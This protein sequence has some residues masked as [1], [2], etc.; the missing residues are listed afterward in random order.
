MQA[1]WIS[2]M[3]LMNPGCFCC[4]NDEVPTQIPEPRYQYVLVD[5]FQDT[6]GA[7]YERHASWWGR[8]ADISSSGVPD[9]P[10]YRFPGADFRSL[11]RFRDDYLARPWSAS[12][13]STARRRPSGHASAVIASNHHRKPVDAVTDQGYGARFKSSKAYERK[14]RSRVHLGYDCQPGV[15]G[16]AARRCGGHAIAPMRGR[17]GRTFH[18]PQP[19]PQTGGNLMRT[20]TNG[21]RV[22]DL[23]PLSLRAVRTTRSDSVSLSRIIQRAPAQRRRKDA[24]VRLRTVEA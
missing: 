6:N 7:Q 19:A 2:T 15:E 16:P 23:L 20:S 24:E 18:S 12:T 11:L 17:A 10:S 4:A 22:K 5:E 13:C 14:R 9:R 21:K 8:G 3:L 1:R